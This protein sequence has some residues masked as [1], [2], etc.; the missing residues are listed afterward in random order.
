MLKPNNFCQS[1]FDYLVVI[2]EDIQF[3]QGR[4]PNFTTKYRSRKNNKKQRILNPFNLPPFFSFVAIVFLFLLQT[5]CTEKME[6]TSPDEKIIVKCWVNDDKQ[7]LYQ[8]NNGE[9]IVVLPSRLGLIMKDQDYATEM[10]MA[11]VSAIS[12]IDESFDLIHGKQR[13]IQYKANQKSILFLNKEGKKMEIIF[14]ASNDGIAF[15]YHFPE[16]SDDKKQIVSEISS[17]TFK[18]DSKA[19][20]QPMSKSKTGWC[21]TNP[22]YEEHYLNEIPV[23]TLSPI[24]EGWVFPALFRSGD[25]WVLITESALDRNYCGARLINHTPEGEYRIGFPEESETWPGMEVYPTSTLPWLSPWRVIALGSL[26]TI[27][28]SNLETALAEPAIEGDFSWVKPGKASWSWVLMKDDNTIF[29]VQKDFIDYAAQMNW[30][31][32]LIDA[33]WDRKIG[34]EKI[35]ELA[36]YAAEKEVGLLLWY[37]SSGS[38][39]STI[40]SPKSK[41]LTHEERKAEFKKIAAMG[42][43]GIKV[44]FF[45]GD[46]QSMIRYYHELMT[47]AAHAGLMINFHGCTYPRSWHRTYPN[48]VTM[49]SIKG[50]EF[51]TFEQANADAAPRH[52]ATLC[53]TRNV[54]S[55]MDFTPMALHSIPHIERR[56]SNVFEL[57]TAVLFLSGI[58]HY[59]ETPVGMATVPDEIQKMITE[60]PSVYDESRLIDGYPGK[61]TVMARRSGNTWYVAG[62]N[63]KDKELSLL[64][65]LSFLHADKGLKVTEGSDAYSF[66]CQEIEIE[67][68]MN[69]EVNMKAKGG[70]LLIVNLKG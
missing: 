50:M 24:G 45:G 13:H 15:R 62:I 64:M 21:E 27:A 7:I 28:E 43:K 2:E 67:D 18:P 69:V 1:S 37:N 63:A 8:V 25:T 30:N 56:T 42:I 44:D 38:W 22:S 26:A 12:K 47:D 10:K 58:Q 23:G 66:N 53:F 57:A 36:K 11:S 32:C 68:K 49:E 19:W 55:P 31:Y 48:L 46:G 3:F 59:A 61:F 9:E 20:L 17:F 41:L 54:F 70:F 29:T 40:Y 5:A 14:R 51:I 6:L 65:D 39:N 34:Y 4:E 35:A 16:S 33:D 60:F 52:C